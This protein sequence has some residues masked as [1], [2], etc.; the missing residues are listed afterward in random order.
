MKSDAHPPAPSRHSVVPESANTAPTLAAGTTER[1]RGLAQDR[2]RAA[3]MVFFLVSGA[4][5]LIYQV[6]WQRLLGI[7]YG[8]GPVSSAIVVSLFMLGLGFGSLAA[9]R[10]S[11]LRGRAVRAYMGIEIAIGIF[12]LASLPLLGFLGRVSGGTDY[13]LVALYS[14][15]FLLVPTFLMGATLP[16]ALRALGASESAPLKNVAA[17]YFVNT[18]GAG[19]GCLLA[20]F[21]L[22]SLLGLDGAIYFAAAL[23]ALLAFALYFLARQSDAVTV[24]S[25]SAAQ[26]Q[27]QRPLSKRILYIAVFVSGF[28]AIGYEMVWFR[29][30]SILLKD[31]IYSFSLLL[32]L[33]LLFLALG[34]FTVGRFVSGKQ[35]RKDLF[36]VINGGIAIAVGAGVCLLFYLVDSLVPGVLMR[37]RP[38]MILPI[39]PTEIALIPRFGFSLVLSAALATLLMGVPAFLMGASFPLLASL[40]PGDDDDPAAAISKVYFAAILG[41][42][43]GALATGFALLPLLG[44]E[45]TIVVF[46]LLGLGFL[47]LRR[48][49]RRRMLPIAAGLLAIAA[50]PARGDLVAFLHDLSPDG[51]VRVLEGVEGTVIAQRSGERLRLFIN[52]SEHGGRPNAAFHLEG[53]TTL[54]MVE[55]PSEVLV[56]G[57]GTASILEATLRDP[58]VRRVTLVEINGT[59]LKALA[60]DVEVGPLLAHPKIEIVVDDARRFLQRTGRKFDAILMDP[61]RSATAFSNNIYSVEFFRLQ[62]EHLNPGGVAMIWTDELT[63]IPNTVAHAFPKVRFYCDMFMVAGTDA[64][65]PQLNPQRLRQI[66]ATYPERERGPIL[67]HRCARNLGERTVAPIASAPMNRDRKPQTEYYL[68]PTFAQLL[69]LRSTTP[70][71][72]QQRNGAALADIANF[73]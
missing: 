35:D 57:I 60:G 73:R 43:T 32:G 69:G 16:V 41:N 3:L 25:D 30:L 33:Y 48:M 54:S 31:S 67:N 72:P 68:G 47:V 23:N 9:G 40:A 62:R 49:S 55:R 56:I 15:L 1:S 58:A 6:V 51:Q 63:A 29:L 36:L 22:I 14:F 37:L 44:S 4:S 5:S 24:R 71:W 70:P 45:R 13:P 59:V 17:Y 50:F 8:V 20:S 2:H 19:I 27:R 11:L 38:A 18:L 42:V 66:L 46:M 61:L 34:S 53:L 7:N 26:E 12:G 28:V 64:T 39:P 10:A 21:V 52:G 65:P